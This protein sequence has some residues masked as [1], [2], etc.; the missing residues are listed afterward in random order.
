MMIKGLHRTHQ[1]AVV[2]VVSEQDL[3]HDDA[4]E[5]VVGRLELGFIVVADGKSIRRDVVAARGRRK[6]DGMSGR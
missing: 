2:T 4:E 5:L 6:R 1:V 3:E